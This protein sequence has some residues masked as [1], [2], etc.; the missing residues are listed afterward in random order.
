L[1]AEVK[2]GVVQ[3]AKLTDFGQSHYQKLD[4]ESDSL[5]GLNPRWLAPEVLEKKTFSE[6][7]DIYGFGMMCYEIV[8]RKIPFSDIRFNNQVEKKILAGEMPNIPENCLFEN[9]IKICWNTNPTQRPTMLEVISILQTIANDNKGILSERLVSEIVDKDTYE[10]DK[11]EM[12]PSMQISLQRQNFSFK[13]GVAEYNCKLY[14]KHSGSIRKLLQVG[15]YVW[16]THENKIRLWNTLHL[17]KNN[18]FRDVNFNNVTKIEGIVLVEINKQTRVFMYG[19]GLHKSYLY[20][21][22]EKCTEIAVVEHKKKR[23]KSVI[24]VQDTVMIFFLIMEK[25]TYWIIVTKKFVKCE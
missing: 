9:L 17:T 8:T 23:V 2:K 25:Y 12:T 19:F 18:A 24:Q 4:I 20:I 10:M 21:L 1:F 7:S 13:Y 15:I 16:A 22:D 14:P 11:K 5:N 6:K 3:I